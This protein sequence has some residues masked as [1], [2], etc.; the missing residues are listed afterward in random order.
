LEDPGDHP[1]SGEA[2]ARF[3]RLAD[4][5]TVLQR[6]V[7]EPLV[8][9]V[10]RVIDTIG[11]EQELDA[12]S[13]AASQ[14]ARDNL[15]LLVE[16]VADYAAHDSYVSLHGLLAYLAAEED[17]NQG[18]SV[19]D[20]TESDAVK[21][22]TIHGAK[23]LEWDA[24]FL[25]GLEEGT[26][27]IRQ[28]VSDPDAL[29]EERRL[30][31]VGITRARRHLTLSWAVGARARPSRFIAELRPGAVAVA[32]PRE[33]VASPGRDAATFELSAADEPLLAQLI[34]WRRQRARSDGVPAYVVAD[35]KTLAAIAAHRPV[36]A[37]GLLSVPGI[38]QRKAAT[39]GEEMLRII[40]GGEPRPMRPP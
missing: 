15:A 26:L 25:P 40:A 3:R 16:T 1:Y 17:Y 27:P 9:L 23:G 24:V 36:D 19:A 13:D 10:R 12:V 29:A 37:G 14:L 34:E 22:M 33:A 20:P 8:E 4:E 31:Y 30:L 5:V 2:Q 38:G 11:I 21:L 35:N 7:G 28:A 32:R 6:H 39:Y 18:L